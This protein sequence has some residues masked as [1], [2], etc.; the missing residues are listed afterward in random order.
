MKSP[1]PHVHR[2]SLSGS[3]CGDDDFGADF[4]FGKDFGVSFGFDVDFGAG[5]GDF[6]VLFERSDATVDFD[7]VSYDFM[8]DWAVISRESGRW[9]RRRR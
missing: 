4:G 1:L 7:N 8:D 3:I 5:F 2:P 6:A 9:G